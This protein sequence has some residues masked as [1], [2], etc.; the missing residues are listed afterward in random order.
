M[1]Y[2]GHPEF[3]EPSIDSKI[4]RYMDLGKFLSL[5]DK[6]AM[7]FSRLDK[8]S[9]FDPFEGYYTRI[10]ISFGNCQFDEM[11]EDW[12]VNSGVNTPEK[13]YRMQAA[14]KKVYDFVKANREYTFVNSWH[15]QEHESA[16]MWKLYL[17]NYEGIAIQSTF[18]KLKNS[19][20]EY[21]EFQ[22]HIGQIKYIDYEKEAIPMGNLLSPFLYKRTSYEYENELRALIWTPQHGKNDATQPDANKYKDVFGLYVDVN[23]DELIDQIYVSPLAPEWI[24]DLIDSLTKKYGLRKQATQSQLSEKPM[25]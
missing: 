2:V 19:L 5:L 25:Y 12:K 7:Y 15:I 20:S 3:R 11:S 8:L 17:S 22:V 6:K 9:K 24:V 16:A 4:W 14:T 21:K 23:L 18:G 1:S 13:F 10:N